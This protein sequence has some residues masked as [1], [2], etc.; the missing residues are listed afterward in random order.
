LGSEGLRV[1][2]Q[3]TYSRARPAS[4]I[5]G[6]NIRS[7][8][9][10]ASLTA[11]YPLIRSRRHTLYAEGGFDLVDQDVT[12]N[13]IPLT[14][15][16]VRIG[17]LRLAGELYDRRTVLRADGYTPYEPK[18]RLRYGAELRQGVGAFGTSPDCRPN[19][20]ACILGGATPPSRIEADPTP[21]LVRLD[22]DIEYRP[23]PDFAIVLR[24]QGQV[25]GDA[26]PAFEEIAAGNFSIG[27]GYDPG[28]VLGDSGILNAFELRF[29]TLVPGGPT[30]VAYQ[31]FA[32]T[33]LAHVWNH[34]PSR[35]AGNPDRLWS[36]GGGVRLAWGGGVQSDLVVAVPLVRPDLAADKG[37]VRLLFTLTARL[38]PWRF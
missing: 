38:F 5:A 18:F 14:R 34:D 6:F 27:R 17:F 31:P 37:D 20:L 13:T 23:I 26:L 30:A 28:A 24:S 11:T 19:L 10:F 16:R 1:G 36:A 32:F 3:L 12:V 22:A 15:D 35:R 9:I 33:D 29:G 4:G 8:T 2:G 7:E 25:T 21:L